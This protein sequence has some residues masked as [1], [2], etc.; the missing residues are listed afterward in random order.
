[1]S[2]VAPV[3]DW[4][5]VHAV[6][7]LSLSDIWSQPPCEPDLDKHLTKQMDR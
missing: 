4:Q 6:T 2:T 5:P 7:R 3:I 1:M